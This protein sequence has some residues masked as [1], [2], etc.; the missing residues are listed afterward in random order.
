M[1]SAILL[2]NGIAL[3]HDNEDHV[4]ATK[5]DILVE[6][7]TITRIEPNISAPQG[8]EVIDCTDKI[9]SP[10]FVDTHHHL[11]QTQLRAKFGDEVLVDYMLKGMMQGSNFTASDVFWGQLG[12]C[13]EAVDAGTT[14]VVDHPHMTYSPEHAENAISATVT[15]GIRS[16]FCYCITMRVS[17]WEPLQLNGNFLE[18]WMFEQLAGLGSRA[19]FGPNGRVQLGLAFDGWFLPK[20]MITDLF[21]RARDA[22][23]KLVTTHYCRGPQSPGSSLVEQIDNFGLLDSRFLISHATGGTPKDASLVRK[24]GV[25]IS[26]TPSTEMQMALGRV[27]CFDDTLKEMAPQCSLGVDLHTNNSAYIPGEMRLALQNARSEFNQ[28]LYDEGKAPRRTHKTVEQAFN[29]GTIMGAR[30]C[31]MGDQIGSL[32]VGKKADVVVFDAATPGMVCCENDP[33]AAI[34]LSSSIR[35]VEIV[36]VDG[37][38]R[39]RDGKLLPVTADEAARGQTGEKELRWREIADSIL[40]SQREILGRIEKIDFEAARKDVLQRFHVDEKNIIEV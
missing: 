22:G 33:V 6:G 40:R 39:K 12:G 9:I 3:L 37:V 15:A 19:P 38:I 20:E 13:M 2:R 16:I 11:W 26:S 4:H 21:Q 14:T 27:A 10:G 18:P 25:H 23:V 8:A 1:S 7:G 5:T 34:V 31:K 32:A 17:C 30:A 36:I 28:K 35:D 29:L 24:A